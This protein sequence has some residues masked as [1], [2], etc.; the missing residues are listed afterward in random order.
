M[1][2]LF[3]QPL[4]AASLVLALS[5][6]LSAVIASSAAYKIRTMDNVLSVT[7]SAKQSITADQA[8]WTVNFSRPVTATTVKEGYV[9]LDRDLQIIKKFFVSNGFEETKLDISTIY[10]DEV[11]ENVTPA[12]EFKK[13]TLRQTVTVISNDVERVAAISKNTKDIIEKGV[14]LAAMAPEYS[15]S[16]LATVRVKLLS[17]ALK[18]ARARAESISSVSGSSVGKL[19]SA[20]GGVVQVLQRGT[21]EVS[22]YGAYDTSSIEKDVMVTVRASFAIN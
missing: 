11:Y 1:K 16:G 13:Y 15:Y 10:M 5:L 20:T 8:K 19:K 18:D 22:D 2:D 14:M 6:L 3:K 4:V 17:D 9:Q 21:N 12:P 7:G